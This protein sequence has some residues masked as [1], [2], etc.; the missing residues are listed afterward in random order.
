MCVGTP[1]FK[2]AFTDVTVAKVQKFNNVAFMF[3]LY[4]K[5]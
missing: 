4:W 2:G 5:G 3:L 1:G